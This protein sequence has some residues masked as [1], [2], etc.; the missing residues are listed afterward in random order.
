MGAAAELIKEYLVLALDILK[1]RWK[2]LLLP[3][4]AA[5]VLSYLAVGLAPTKY[6][7]NSVILLQAANR[8]AGNTYGGVQYSNTLE[9]V[10]AIEAWLK[11]DQVL[12][13]LLPQMQGWKPAKSDVERNIQMRI[14][15]SSLSLEVVGNSVLQIK[16]TSDRPE[17]LGRNL[18]AILARMMEGLTGPE[19]NIL[20]APQFVNIRRN[21]EVATAEAALTQALAEG[22]FQ[23]PLQVR[24]SLEQLRV[25]KLQAQIPGRVN[26]GASAPSSEPLSAAVER[27][28]NGISSDAAY[29]DRLEHLY[30]TYKQAADKQAAIKVQAG[31]VRSNYVSIFNSP[32]DLLIIGRPKDP[33]VGESA[34]RKLAIAGIMFSV[35]VGAGLVLLTELLSGLLRTRRDHETASGLPIL[36]RVPNLAP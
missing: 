16:M 32:D 34:A 1:R 8:N 11:T 14:L 29:V 22:D 15:A 9:Q 23:A 7:A 33:L 6:T 28:R 19:Q 12:A 35:L 3:I 2:L 17:N 13:D 18:E 20:S 25:L 4:L 24:V 36:A 31:P 21:E 30:D 5:I 27:L 10:Q 26:S